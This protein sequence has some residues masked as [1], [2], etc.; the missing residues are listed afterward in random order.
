[1][2]DFGGTATLQGKKADWPG[3]TTAQRGMQGG[4]N[5][6]GCLIDSRSLGMSIQK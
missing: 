3:V 4:V 6:G 1:M 2:G 5:A